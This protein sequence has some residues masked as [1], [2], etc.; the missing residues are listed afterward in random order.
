MADTWIS[1]LEAVLR[2][3]RSLYLTDR[4]AKP[5]LRSAVGTGQVRGRGE[6]QE[7]GDALFGVRTEEEAAAV[8]PHT[9][10]GYLYYSLE[11][12]PSEIELRSLSAWIAGLEGRANGA[13]PLSQSTTAI[14]TPVQ[15][16][17]LEAYKAELQE[18]LSASTA[19]KVRDERIRARMRKMGHQYAA[20]AKTI[21]SALK[22]AGQD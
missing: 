10:V 22:S 8:G 12:Y 5:L 17:I 14:L 19:V 15:N 20:D 9:R 2:V 6:V 7:R 11:T 4:S 13:S 16:A 1:F 21:R 3:G 18:G